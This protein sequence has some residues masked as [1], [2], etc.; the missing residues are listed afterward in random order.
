[1]L[2]EDIMGQWA[3]D[4]GERSQ[5]AT[6]AVL[7]AVYGLRDRELGRSAA[8]AAREASTSPRSR[9]VEDGTPADWSGP[10]AEPL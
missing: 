5:R 6:D 7:T 3:F 2:I 8:E 1:M 10:P 4:G 9:R